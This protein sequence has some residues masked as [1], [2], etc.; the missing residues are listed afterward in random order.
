MKITEKFMSLLAFSL[1]I[2]LV[3]AF[4]TADEIFDVKILP[5]GHN[6]TLVRPATTD[7]PMFT[8]INLAATDAPQTIKFSL[9][10]KSTEKNSL[11]QLEVVDNRHKKIHVVLDQKRDFLYSFSNLGSISVILDQT[12]G[13]MEQRDLV[14]R[15]ES[16]K[17]LTIAR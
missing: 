5:P 2:P 6:I 13:K 9:I 15:V 7:V 3:T 16:D 4:S 17:P 11:L 12:H 1:L 14:L 10:G 8:R